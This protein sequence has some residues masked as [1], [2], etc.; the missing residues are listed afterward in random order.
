MSD[1]KNKLNKLKDTLKDDTTTTKPQ[2]NE[3]AKAKRKVTTKGDSKQLFALN[4]VY[5]G[6][7]ASIAIQKSNLDAGITNDASYFQ[8]CTNKGYILLKDEEVK[9][10]VKQYQQQLY[11]SLDFS[12]KDIILQYTQ[13]IQLAQIQGNLKEWRECLKEISKLLGFDKQQI[14]ITSGGM[15]IINFIANQDQEVMQIIE[16][17]NIDLDNEQ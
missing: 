7:N 1:L 11:K 3:V 8:K 14:D 13:I 16:D 5:S 15:P 2:K 9:Q 6:Y 4:Y 17:L 10:Y 12:I